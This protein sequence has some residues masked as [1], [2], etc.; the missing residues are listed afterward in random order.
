[1]TFTRAIFVA[2]PCL[3]FERVA[4]SIEWTGIR[5]AIG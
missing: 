2:L 1:V 4:L 5:G 3:S